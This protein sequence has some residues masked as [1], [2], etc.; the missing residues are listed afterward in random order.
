MEDI[1]PSTKKSL[2]RI[3]KLNLNFII[4]IICFSFLYCENVDELGCITYL[5]SSNDEE[6]FNNLLIFNS[7]K[8]QASN[9]A[10]DKNEGFVIGFSEDNDDTYSKLLYGLKND[11]RNYFSDE[12]STYEKK[13]DK[14]DLLDDTGYYDYFGI[15]KSINLFISLKNDKKKNQYLFSVNSYNSIVELHD[16]NNIN[17]NN[18]NLIWSFNDFFNLD[19]DV[20]IFPYQYH[21]FEL[22]KDS[23]YIVKIIEI[24]TNF[25]KLFLK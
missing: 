13:F 12:S 3:F 22:K 17:T 7:R 4:F 20:Y 9:F 1:F 6:C 2:N 23:E 16:F 25:I 21:I 14:E 10:M 5:N 24:M 15:Y 8:Y 18:S 19:E 11:G